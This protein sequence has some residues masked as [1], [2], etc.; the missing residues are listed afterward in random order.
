MSESE[1]GEHYLGQEAEW[2]ENTKY[3]AQTHT[4]T[5]R[6]ETQ[7]LGQSQENVSFANRSG[8][9]DLQEKRRDASKTQIMGQMIYCLHREM[10]LAHKE[11]RQI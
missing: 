3:R 7:A 1:G 4:R 5:A 11:R 8:V 2:T 9:D 10:T 6:G